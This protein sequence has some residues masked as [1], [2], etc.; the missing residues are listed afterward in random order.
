[1]AHYP[2]C[3]SRLFTPDPSGIIFFQ[4]VIL[5]RQCLLKEQP[6]RYWMA[7]SGL[8]RWSPLPCIP[9]EF[10]E[11]GGGQIDLVFV[12]HID[13]YPIAELTSACWLVPSLYCIIDHRPGF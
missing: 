5:C 7:C 4:I 3:R 12:S 6:A 1:M 9:S 13:E 8:L 11:A 10:H 2:K